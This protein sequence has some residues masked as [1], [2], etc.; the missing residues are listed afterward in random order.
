ML[1]SKYAKIVRSLDAALSDGVL[2]NASTKLKRIDDKWR[3]LPQTDDSM[4][5]ADIYDLE[6]LE[7]AIQEYISAVH[8]CQT[9]LGGLRSQ[10]D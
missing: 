8:I 2:S 6:T 5:A 9:R 4:S 1:R 10:E 7:D 3:I